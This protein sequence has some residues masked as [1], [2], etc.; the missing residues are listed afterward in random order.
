MGKQSKSQA[1][2]PL[3]DLLIER[4]LDVP[5]DRVWRAWTE[6][7][8]IKPWFTPKPWITSACEV[9]LRPGGA[10]NITMRTPEG[11]EYPNTNCYLEI[12]EK[13]KIIWTNALHAGFRPAGASLGAPLFTAIIAMEP[14]QKG[15]KYSVLVL[16]SSEDDANRHKEMGFFE[17]WG[18]CID[19]LTDYA[20]NRMVINTDKAAHGHKGAPNE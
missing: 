4:I 19:Q 18:T 11:E 9:D 17:G 12:Q 15:T 3:T 13:V 1:I 5:C 14:H 10:F 20:K 6:P 8:H 2:N 7:E 16:H